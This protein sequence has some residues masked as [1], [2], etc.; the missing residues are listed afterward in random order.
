MGQY[1]L[2]CP[3]VAFVCKKSCPGSTGQKLAKHSRCVMQKKRGSS[4]G[5]WYSV[6]D[7]EWTAIC[8]AVREKILC[9]CAG[10]GPLKVLQVRTRILKLTFC[11]SEKQCSGQSNFGMLEAWKQ[12][13]NLSRTFFKY[14]GMVPLSQF[15]RHTQEVYPKHLYYKH[16]KQTN[17]TL[18]RRI[19]SIY[20]S[21]YKGSICKTQDQEF[22]S[23]S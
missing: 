7:D 10:A 9:L 18:T 15:L 14:L 5:C 21:E 12:A 19:F 23:P 16:I 4:L 2:R 11:F 20:K 22:S 3:R 17:K 1:M 6:V 13:S 8:S